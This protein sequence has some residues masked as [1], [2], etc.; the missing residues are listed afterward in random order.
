MTTPRPARIERAAFCD[1]LSLLGPDQPT[2]CSPW[3]TKDLA[4]HVVIR[5][6]RPDAAAGITL[7]FLADHTASVLAKTASST[8]FDELTDLIRR[9]PWY[10][11][12]ALGP[13]DNATNTAEFFL[14]T[15]D[16]RRAQPDWSPRAL[17]P[18]VAA[19]LRGQMRFMSKLRLRKYPA[20]LKINIT[21]YETPIITGDSNGPA[22]TLSGDVGEL[23]LF[24]SG[25]QRVSLAVVEGPEDAAAALRTA[26]FGL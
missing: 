11:L 4:A 26:D 19:A 7:P 16:A 15:E 6:R 21:G 23:T 22:L 10:S 3:T 24:L 8:S 14:H 20:F 9:P 25:R 13:T 1:T 5:E 18:S 17:M 2:L 12:A